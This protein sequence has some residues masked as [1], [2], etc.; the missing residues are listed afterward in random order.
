MKIS[1]ITATYNSS[2]T[3]NSV[4]KSLKQ[5]TFQDFEWVVVDGSS[6]DD[7]VEKVRSS[8][9]NYKLLS[10]KDKGIYDALNKGVAMASGD[11]ISFLHSDDFFENENVLKEI[12]TQFQ[13]TD[14]DGIY[15]NLKYVSSN[16]ISKVIRFWKSQPFQINNL[17]KG[18]MP[19]HPTLFLKK[20]VYQKHGSFDLTFAIAAD[21]DFMLRIFKDHELNFKYIPIVITN[22]RTGGASNSYS[23]LIKK[24]K[25]D[26][27]AIRKND[28][29]RLD[30]LFFKN[31]SKI[32]Q[33]FRR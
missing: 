5:Q 3:L 4:V 23:N 17:K 15:G 10:E 20:E 31:T 26:F 30:V 18:W 19:P 13:K 22:M 32:P 25:E 33:L 6:T 2:Q 27:K 28:I 29:G 11:I 24:M 16:N 1:I 7:T 21:Y 14:A 12:M 9:L 8:G